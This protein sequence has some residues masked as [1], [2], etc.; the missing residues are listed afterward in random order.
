[1]QVTAA[2]EKGKANAAVVDV[3]AEALDLP[4]SALR[5]VSGE[6]SP[7]KTVEIDGDAGLLGLLPPR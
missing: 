6:T 4:K 2:P 5:I 3:L 7:L 1:V